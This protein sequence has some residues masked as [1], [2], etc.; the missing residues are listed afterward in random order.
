MTIWNYDFQKKSI[1]KKQF[2]LLRNR[3]RDER[4]KERLNDR[5]REK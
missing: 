3:V 1:F 5:E 2:F 4:E